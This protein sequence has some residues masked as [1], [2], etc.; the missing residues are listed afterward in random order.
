[1][2]MG[3]AIVTMYGGA[4][5]A[6]DLTA[7]VFDRFRSLPVWRG[8]FVIGGLPGDAGRYLLAAAIVVTLGVAIGYRPGGGAPGVVAAVALV[9]AFA[10]PLSWLWTVVALLILDA[11]T[12]VSLASVVLFPLTFANNVF[13]PARTMPDWI[14]AFVNANPI[15]HIASAARALMNNTGGVGGPVI[16]SLVAMAAVTVVVRATRA[17][18]VRQARMTMQ[19]RQPLIE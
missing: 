1:M 4:R 8:A 11:A 16:W 7:A 6:D 5:L 15:S 14:Q 17:P 10:V 13:V 19:S 12:V 2:V 3:V 9:V 18:P